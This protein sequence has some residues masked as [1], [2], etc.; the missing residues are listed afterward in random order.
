MAQL[1]DPTVLLKNNENDKG[2][3]SNNTSQ[4]R[5]PCSSERLKKFVDSSDKDRFDGLSC[6]RERFLKEDLSNES[7]NII[8]ASRRKSTSIKYQVYINQWLVINFQNAS[9]SNGLDFLTSLYQNEKQ[10]PNIS[11]AKSILS[12]FIRSSNGLEFGKQFIVQRF[13]K[14]IYQ[15][16]PSLPKYS[17]TWDISILF[18]KCR[19]LP[20]N[21]QL[22][23][24]ALTLKT[25]TLL[26]LIIFTLDLRYL[27]NDKDTIHI[28]FPSVLKHSGPGRH[29]KPVILKRHLA[30]TKTCPVEVLHTY[31]KTTKE[32]RK[33]KTKLLISFLKPHSAVT[34]KTISRSIKISLKE[35][36]FDTNTYQ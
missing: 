1:T 3:P 15:L 11:C 10:Y 24:K 14:G 22:D 13:M 35:A 9:F 8:M 26:T 31:L 33:N 5:K 12:L 17:F 29:L 7:T 30:D 21:D 19:E 18:E 36:G 25:A 34:V 16:R 20:P 2:T 6:A 27:K 28:A 32:I 23:L 4:H